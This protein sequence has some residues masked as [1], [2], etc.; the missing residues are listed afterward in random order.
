[1]LN[2]MSHL[3]WT[4][5]PRYL[6]KHYCTCFCESVFWRRFT[7]SLVDFEYSRSCYIMWVGPIP[8]AEGLNKM[9]DWSSL[10][11]K[12]F[13]QQTA[14]RPELR[15]FPGPSGYRCPPS[16]LR[17]TMPPQLSCQ[18]VWSGEEITH[19]EIGCCWGVAMDSKKTI[20]KCLLQLC[21]WVQSA[22]CDRPANLLLSLWCTKFRTWEWVFSICILTKETLCPSN[23]IIKSLDLGFVV[24][25]WLSCVQ[26]CDPQGLQPTRLL[27]PPLSPRVCSNSCPSSLWCHLTISFSATPF[28]FCLQS[29]PESGSFPMSQL[30]HQVAKVLELQVFF[31][32]FF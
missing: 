1:M 18:I 23:L 20:N 13:F 29:F 16:H 14:L 10:N 6:V 31:A 24:V 8:S 4:M 21:Y 5:I 2:F 3:G 15:L 26:L 9:K 32:L 25:Q 19:K 28:S 11:K 30:F 22:D 17:L 7:F 27:C 12:E